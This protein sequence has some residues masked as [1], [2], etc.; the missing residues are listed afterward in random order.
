MKCPHGT[1]VLYVCPACQEQ[2]R[3]ERMEEQQMEVFKQLNAT[4]AALH[5]QLQKMEHPF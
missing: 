4:L 2:A 5:K 3:R 1:D